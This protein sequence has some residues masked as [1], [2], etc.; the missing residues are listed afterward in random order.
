MISALTRGLA[1]KATPAAARAPAL[2]PPWARIAILVCI[3]LTYTLAYAWSAPHT[4]TADE[5]LHGYAIRHGIS[6]PLEGPFLGQA[7]HLGPAW[8]RKLPRQVDSSLLDSAMSFSRYFAGG[9]LPSE[10]CGRIS[11]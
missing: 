2:F 8:F 4:D 10:S 6:Y 1:A 11:L 5:L 3:V 7:I 9:R